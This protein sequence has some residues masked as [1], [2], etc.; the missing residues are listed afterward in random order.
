MQIRSPFFYLGKVDKVPLHAEGLCR[1]FPYI[2]TL[3][4]R[5]RAI[6]G[7]IIQ[8]FLFL[9]VLPSLW[10]VCAR[11]K[12]TYAVRATEQT[13][14]HTHTHT[15]HKYIYPLSVDHDDGRS[16]FLLRRIVSVSQGGNSRIIDGV[17]VKSLEGCTTDGEIHV[18]YK[19]PD[20]PPGQHCIWQPETHR[21]EKKN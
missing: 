19:C 4:S 5:A 16:N 13:H 11:F 10:F 7:C 18:G 9:L 12:S 3:T 6:S 20:S 21:S 8:L 15:P 2:V 14:T 17:C 1:Q